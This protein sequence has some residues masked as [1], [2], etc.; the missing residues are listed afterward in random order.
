MLDERAM[1]TEAAKR[2]VLSFMNQVKSRAAL[3]YRLAARS[4]RLHWKLRRSQARRAERKTRSARPARE[5]LRTE[6]RRG[7]PVTVE[8]AALKML[9][10]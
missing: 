9:R 4:A 1:N 5:R 8:R 6:S 7:S 3:R 10:Y 2:S